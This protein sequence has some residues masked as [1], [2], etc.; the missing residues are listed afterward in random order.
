MPGPFITPTP[1]QRLLALAKILIPV[2]VLLAVYQL[3]RTIAA[4]E[5]CG[6]ACEFLPMMRVVIGLGTAILLA[7]IVFFGSKGLRVLRSGQMPPP[8]TWVLL[9]T[10]V[11]T[12]AWARLNA[13]SYFLFCAGAVYLLVRFVHFFHADDLILLLLGIEPCA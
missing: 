12:G 4:R 10:R 7:L 3:A 13:L 8:G 6:S 5:P 9:R 11:R 1:G 2:V